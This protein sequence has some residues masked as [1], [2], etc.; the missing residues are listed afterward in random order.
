[1]LSSGSVFLVILGF[2]CAVVGALS[3]G[4]I[5][6]RLRQFGVNLA[7]WTSVQDDLNS[8]QT[9][10]QYAKDHRVPMWPLA[11]EM[12]GL[13]GGFLLIVAAILRG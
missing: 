5:R 4:Y 6:G 12:L 3:R 2:A 8:A 13:L 11:I 10:L 1:M 9:Y 7:V